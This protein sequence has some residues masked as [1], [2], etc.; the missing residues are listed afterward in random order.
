MPRPTASASSFTPHV[1]T[2]TPNR[3]SAS[4]LSALGHRDE[5]HVVDRSARASGRARPRAPPPR[6]ARYRARCAAR[7][8]RMPDDRPCAAT[9]RRVWMYPNSRSPCAAWFRFMKSKSMSAQGSST[10]ACVCRCASGFCSASSP[11]D[12]HLRGLNVCIHATR[13]ITP[14]VGVG[15]QCGA[16]DGRGIR[17]HRLPDDPDRNLGRLVEQP[18]D[19]LRLRRDLRERLGTVEVLAA[20]EEPDLVAVEGGG[21]RSAGHE[22][23]LQGFDGGGLDGQARSVAVEIGGEPGDIGRV[24]GRRC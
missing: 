15:L 19:L 1:F 13:P 8:G 5:A 23:S 21:E 11:G 17:Q 16:L 12:P 3:S 4:V 2:C 20:G 10:L 24:V 6:A 14:V 18:R 7:V 22:R 9:P